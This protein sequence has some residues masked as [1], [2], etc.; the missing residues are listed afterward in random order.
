MLFSY[1]LSNRL[2]FDLRRLAIS[3]RS[4]KHNV[5]NAIVTQSTIIARDSILYYTLANKFLQSI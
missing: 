3:S 1:I 2:S 4:P 5:T